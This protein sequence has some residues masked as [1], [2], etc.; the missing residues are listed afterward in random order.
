L[1]RKEVLTPFK[2]LI[3]DDEINDKYNNI[4]TL[5]E[6]LKATGY[7]VVITPDGSA[8]YDLVLACKPDL[9]ILDLEFKNQPCQ[10]YG[11]EICKAIRSNDPLIPII[12]ITHIHTE[13]SDILDGFKLG[14][15]D[16]VIAPYDNRVIA[17]RIRANLP[18]EVLVVDDWQ[19]IDLVSQQVYVRRDRSW[20]EV[21]LQRLEFELLKTL[22]ENGGTTRPTTSL[23]NKVWEDKLVSDDVLAVF[24]HRLRVKLDPDSEHP[25]FIETIKGLGYRVNGK[26]VHASRRSCGC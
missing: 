26:M 10:G 20:K 17:A 18:P 1:I 3:A 19:C 6:F 24:I 8:V 22:V 23:K 12:L 21:N 2:I 9:V 7:D 15:S 4:S 25:G 11:F 14:I 16:Y 13:N 5:P